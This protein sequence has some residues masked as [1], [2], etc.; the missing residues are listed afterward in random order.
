[1]EHKKSAK[2]WKILAGI[3]A[4]VVIVSG[5]GIFV[6]VSNAYQPDETALEAM[7]GSETVQVTADSTGWFFDGPGSTDAFIFY[8]GANVSP[9]AYAP[10]LLSLSEKGLDCFLVKMPL[11]MAFLGV[12][13]AQSIID[14]NTYAC[15]YIGGHSLGGAMAA[16]FCASHIEELDG[17]ILLAA[18]PTAKLEKEDFFVLSI[19]GSKDGVLNLEKVE[20]TLEYMPTH[21]TIMEIDG[22]NHAQFG[23]Y[24]FQ[25]KDQKA[26]LS[27][28]KQQ[29]LTVDAI[30]KTINEQNHSL[31]P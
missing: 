16:N 10:L 11:N 21:Y 8:P 22:G 23:D 3:L 15:W 14:A 9:Q 26:S 12:N 29:A 31:E 24:G 13:K 18:Y 7:K 4:A 5:A 6:F 28:Q 19:Y 2:V 17:L 20:E 30:V 25:K 27:A 1:M